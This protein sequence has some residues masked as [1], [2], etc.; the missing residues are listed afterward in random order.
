MNSIKLNEIDESVV[1]E[2]GLAGVRLLIAEDEAAIRSFMQRALGRWGAEATVVE[3]AG[4]AIDIVQREDF[5]IVV[6][7]VRMPGGGGVEAYRRIVDSKPNLASRIVF[8]TGE[9]SAEM[10]E[11][12]GQ[13][14]AC[15]LQKPF[16]L[17]SLRRAI[18]KA[19]D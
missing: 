4:Q 8:M 7:D 14:Y 18:Q 15:V 1:A 11:I 5:D 16:T 17:E 12:V 2:R 19:L 13:D 10:A 3:D 9:L 6:L